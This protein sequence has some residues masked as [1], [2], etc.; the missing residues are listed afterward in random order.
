MT[1]KFTAVAVLSLIGLSACATPYQEMG[2]RGGVASVRITSDIAQVTARGT[3]ATDPDQVQRYALRKAAET[4][5]ASGYDLFQVVADT[6]RSRTVQGAAGYTAGGLGGFPAIGLNLPFVKP[7]QTF[8]IRMSRA[9]AAG[10]L[11]GTVFNAHEVLE[12]LGG[13]HRS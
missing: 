7:G 12:N 1:P 10:D 8:L 6:D 3:A 11:A 4:T 5:V 9:Q 13:R 2:V